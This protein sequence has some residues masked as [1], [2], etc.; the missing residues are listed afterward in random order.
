MAHSDGRAA[1]HA[2]EKGVINMK[3][4]A[5]LLLSAALI[6]ALT[7]CG[8]TGNAPANVSGDGE[9]ES[10]DVPDNSGNATESDR[11]DDAT[12][13]VSSGDTESSVL[14]FQSVRFGEKIAL[15]FV[16]IT[17]TE[18]NFGEKMYVSES[19]SYSPLEGNY[20]FWLSCKLTNLMGDSFSLTKIKVKLTFDG[21]YN[22]E[23]QALANVYD[24]APLADNTIFICGQV[25]PAILERYQTVTFQFAFNDNFA[26][27]AELE[28]GDHRYALTY[29]RNGAPGLT[30]N[31]AETVESDAEPV[32]AEI[33]EPVPASIPEPKTNVTETTSQILYLGF[34]DIVKTNDYEFTLNKVKFS[35]D[36]L[37]DDTSGY[38]RHYTPE[39]GHVY[40]DI[41]ASVKNLMK[42]D[43][44]L[45][46]L[47]TAK[48]FYGDGYTYSGFTV[49]SDGS[50]FNFANN[51]SVAA[52]LATCHAHCI[53]ECPQEVEESLKTLY[54]VIRL[55]D[56]NDYRYYIR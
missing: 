39:S 25:P 26:T 48:A 27:W 3:R 52:P 24:M 38:Y 15:D 29:Q 50:R 43:I 19:H 5:A 40:I 47:F 10:A 51:W 30:E 31:G 4:L 45:G 37:P 18:V 35:Y 56:G 28:S 55:A 21:K 8:G 7:A 34:G 6:W 16:E 14:G 53:I 17:P 32:G 54:V 1:A 42:R 20:Y 11:P 2:T 9:P 13:N 41:D 36:V 22:Y 46:E 33:A 49:V 23:G 12:E 44:A